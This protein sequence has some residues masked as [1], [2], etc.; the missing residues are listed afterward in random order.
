MTDGIHMCIQHERAPVAG[1]TH[2]ADHIRA[3]RRR[4][5]HLGFDAIG[6]EPLRHEDADFPFSPSAGL[7]IGVDRID[8]HQGRH[9]LAKL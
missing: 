9:Q 4:F 3:A 2:D 8:A 1:S 7:E 5:L 6:A